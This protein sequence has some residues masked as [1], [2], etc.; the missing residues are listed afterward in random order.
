[1]ERSGLEPS[2]R[3]VDLL[4]IS[5]VLPDTAYTLN[6]SVIAAVTELACRT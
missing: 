1:M 5:K 2:I 4:F 6:L 3:R